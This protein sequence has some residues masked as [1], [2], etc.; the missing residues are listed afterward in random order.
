M[1]QWHHNK[2]VLQPRIIRFNTNTLPGCGTNSC[3]RWTLG[4]GLTETVPSCLGKT[5]GGLKLVWLIRDFLKP[6]LFP[7]PYCTRKSLPTRRNPKGSAELYALRL[8]KWIPIALSQP[9]TRLSMDGLGARARHL[10]AKIL[11]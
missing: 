1:R 9:V 11:K 6:A 2:Q 5:D 7:W 3:N 8:S 4:S 10:S